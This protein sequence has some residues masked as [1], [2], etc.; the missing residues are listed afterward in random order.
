MNF[1]AELQTS[2]GEVIRH[3][4]VVA[5]DAQVAL[6]IAWAKLKPSFDERVRIL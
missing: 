6:D 3:V 2:S 1:R 4:D 5:P